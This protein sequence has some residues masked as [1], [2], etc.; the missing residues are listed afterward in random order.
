M[1]PLPQHVGSISVRRGGGGRSVLF[2][3]GIK[4][5][6][7]V[8]DSHVAG[9]RQSLAASVSMSTSMSMSGTIIDVRADPVNLVL[10]V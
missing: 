6:S 3:F 8:I 7:T 1:R 5:A 4:L 2:S 10:A 9:Y